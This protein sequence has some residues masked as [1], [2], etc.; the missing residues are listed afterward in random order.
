MKPVRSVFHCKD[1]TYILHRISRANGTSEASQSGPSV[2]FVS[3]SSFP[4]ENMVTLQ[5]TSSWPQSFR[6]GQSLV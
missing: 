4:N 5:A 6:H 3:N 2:S 1:N